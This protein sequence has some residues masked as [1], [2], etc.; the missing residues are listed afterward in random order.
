MS[1]KIKG[2]IPRVFPKLIRCAICQQDKA[3]KFFVADERYTGGYK[4]RCS[5]CKQVPYDGRLFRGFLVRIA[6]RS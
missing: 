5:D 4:P 3:S 1:C 6:R 2:T